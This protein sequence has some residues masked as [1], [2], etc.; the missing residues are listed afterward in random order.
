MRKVIQ[1]HLG[2]P[3]A[4]DHLPHKV[5]Q[6][7]RS[8]ASQGNHAAALDKH[9]WFHQHALEYNEA[10][11]GVRLSFALAA[12]VELGEKYP[13]ARQALLSVR[14]DA[15]RAIEN[16]EGSFALFHD[17]AAINQH[18]Q[19]E[20]HTVEI[21]RLV[22]HRHPDLAR[23]CYPVAER[24]LVDHGEYATCISSVPDLDKRLEAIRELQQIT[25]EMAQQDPILGTP[26]AGL[27]EFAQ[28]RFVE[29]TS[30]LSAILEG[31]GR[32][33][34]AERVREFMRA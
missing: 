21:F 7:A 22:H 34:E 8:L 18:L 24:V 17:V 5:L 27:R 15:T 30:R 29:E 6:E 16:G 10:L 1:Q 11:A 32:L 19:D 26:D 25:L 9:L 33:Q 4:D 23:E 13:P 14:A 28:L 2:R 31:V 12:W 20:A 3:S